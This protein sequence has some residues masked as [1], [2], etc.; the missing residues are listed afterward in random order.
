MRW[1]RARIVVTN[2]QQ[3]LADALNREVNPR[4]ALFRQPD[5][6]VIDEAHRFEEAA[7]QMLGSSFTFKDIRR[8]PELVSHLESRFMVASIG[9]SKLEELGPPLIQSLGGAVKWTEDGESGRAFIE[10]NKNLETKIHRYLDAL[11]AVT[12]LQ[13]LSANMQRRRSELDTMI[14]RITAT[15]EALV[16]P[17]EFVSWAEMNGAYLESIS[18]VPRNMSNRLGELLWNYRCP[19]VLTSDLN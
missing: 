1:P 17:D 8:M 9:S 18:A 15:M 16:N 14:E 19:T 4:I 10:I 12:G 5:M 7:A 11:D 2:H 3:L 13:T 6:V